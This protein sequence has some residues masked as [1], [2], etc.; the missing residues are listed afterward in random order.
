MGKAEVKVAV[1]MGAG[2][3]RF[4]DRSSFGNP[5]AVCL[6]RIGSIKWHTSNGSVFFCPLASGLCC[7]G[8]C[9][10]KWLCTVQWPRYTVNYGVERYKSTDGKTTVRYQCM[11]L[12]SK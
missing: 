11:I 12:F 4:V 10:N 5:P 8:S 2:R 3:V 6:R 9:G 7:S 1:V